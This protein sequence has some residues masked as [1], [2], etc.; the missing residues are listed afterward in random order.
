M[1]WHCCSRLIGLYGVTAYN[2]ARRRNE[3][4]IRM[5][6]GANRLQI[7]LY[8]L[9]GAWVQVLLGLLLGLPIAM[10]IGRLVSARLYKVGTIDPVSFGVPRRLCCCLPWLQVACRRGAR[11][12]SS[13][14]KRYEPNECE[15]GKALLRFERK[16]SRR[17]DL[18]AFLKLQM[19]SRLGLMMFLEYF[20][21]GSWYVTMYVALLLL[22]L[23][24]RAGGHR[25]RRDRG[26]G[27]CGAVL[28]RP[29]RR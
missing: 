6:I 28:C 27:D 19:K 3:I 4:G 2:V 26:R 14:W 9:R 29:G 18:E 11:P 15:N 5:A 7:A 23:H 22:A 16:S 24:G 1:A 10:L 21:W 20:V 25:W 13:R 17:H 8:F 12:P